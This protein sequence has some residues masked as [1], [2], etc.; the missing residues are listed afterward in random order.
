MNE[1]SPKILP[2]AAGLIALFTLIPLAAHS[3]APQRGD[4]LKQALV[5]FFED[6]EPSAALAPGQPLHA[7]GAYP[8]TATTVYLLLENDPLP[9]RRFYPDISRTVMDL[10]AEP[11]LAGG[12]VRGMPGAPKG[13]GSIL[14]PGLNALA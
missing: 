13:S 9:L 3:S 7:L 2:I 5:R 14:S 4:A 12:L 6:G 8:I 1:R 10:F 11:N